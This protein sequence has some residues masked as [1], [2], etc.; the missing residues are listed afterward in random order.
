MI[1]KI[2]LPITDEEILE[3]HAGDIVSVSG[4]IY[5]ARDVAH[6]RMADAIKNNES[7]P[8]DWKG[9]GVYYAG[10]APA[11]PGHVIGSV[12]PTTSYRMDSQTPLLLEK[13]LKVMIGKG[14]RSQEVI[15]AMKK[16][17][18]VYLAA[19]GG[20]AALLSKSVISSEMIAYDDLGTEAIRKFEIKDFL[21]TV[22]IDCYGVNQYDEGPKAFAALK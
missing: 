3:L 2:T 12:G 9:Q 13:G 11:K 17:H 14:R 15:D 21:A 18:A 22:A 10:P 20:V 1:K 5:T 6:Q 7:L 8:V 16:Y 4:V 19:T